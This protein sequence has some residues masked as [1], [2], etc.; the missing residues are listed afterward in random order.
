M[1]RRLCSVTIFNDVPCI[2]SGLC[3]TQLLLQ[4]GRMSAWLCIN[5]G[6]EQSTFTG[7]L[8]GLAWK[9]GLAVLLLL[10]LTLFSRI[11]CCWWCLTSLYNISAGHGDM[12]AD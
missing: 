7:M 6:K 3:R 10:L 9:V 11:P 8:C 4:A 2:S 1:H 5:A 12:D